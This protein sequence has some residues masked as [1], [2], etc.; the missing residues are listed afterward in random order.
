MSPALSQ[1]FTGL[2]F[3]TELAPIIRDLPVTV[4]AD[5]T[6]GLLAPSKLNVASEW[7]PASQPGLS[8]LVSLARDGKVLVKIS[9]LYRSS[10]ATQTNFSDMANIIRK[11]A[12]LIPD[13]LIWGSDWPHTGE[14][15]TRLSQ[16]L[17]AIEPFRVIDDLAIIA[18]LKKWVGESTWMKMMVTNP[19]REFFE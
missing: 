5:H 12:V 18:N 6:G 3:L 16:D 19:Q 8:S 17:Q 15:K 1:Q 2:I 14:G 4:I 13:H 7:S 10:D 11:L 9:G